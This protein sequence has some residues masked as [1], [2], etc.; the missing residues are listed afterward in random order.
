MEGRYRAAHEH[1][2]GPGDARPTALQIIRDENLDDGSLSGKVILI[3]GC[4]SGLGV[5]TARALKTSE[6]FRDFHVS[7]Q[8]WGFSF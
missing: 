3:T 6:Y 5:E 7:S 4:S 8:V 2:K 1:P